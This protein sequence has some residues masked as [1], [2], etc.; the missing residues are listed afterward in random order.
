MERN[1]MWALWNEPG[2][3]H[4][5]L[6]QENDSIIIDSVIIGIDNHTP[7]RLWYEM[8]C[9]TNWKVRELGLISLSDKGKNIKIQVNA[10]GRWSTISGEVLPQLDGCIDV[11]ISV[12]PFTNT[13]PIRRL[14]LSPGQS[15]ELLVAYVAAP[16]LEL[17]PAK[18]RYTCLELN[19]QG[20]VYRYEGLETGFSR[21]LQVDADGLVID[22]P[23]IWRRVKSL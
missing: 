2:L 8:V 10:E 4:L 13:L 11:D 6:L 23:G 14:A 3:E 9:D 16:A 12:T 21:E 5:H 1:I 19:P 17:K 20:A 18:Q 22:Y 15:A 7:F